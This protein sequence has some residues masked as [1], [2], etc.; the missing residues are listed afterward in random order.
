[1][2]TKSVRSNVATMLFVALAVSGCAAETTEF[3]A[4]PVPAGSDIWLRGDPI[5]TDIA[6]HLDREQDVTITIYDV[7]G[8]S[9]VVIQRGPLD[10]GE[11]ILHWDGRLADGTE[12]A[13][14]V[15]FATIEADDFTRTRR[16]MWPPGRMPRGRIIAE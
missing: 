1:M 9:V 8:D 11:H 7:R 10:V 5:G 2:E 13:H 14:G 6:F 16:L 12:A 3:E 15:Y 4:V